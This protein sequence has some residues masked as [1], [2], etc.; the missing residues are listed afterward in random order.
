MEMNGQLQAVVDSPSGKEPPVSSEYEA[1]WA[2]QP[3]W[4]L[5]SAPN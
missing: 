2:P 1:G 3:G 4:T 5:V